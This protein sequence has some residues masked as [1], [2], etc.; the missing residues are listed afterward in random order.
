[1]PSANDERDGDAVRRAGWTREPRRGA[2]RTHATDLVR[3]GAHLRGVQAARPIIRNLQ[4][5]RRL[6]ARSFAI[7]ERPD[8]QSSVR[9]I[10][11]VRHELTLGTQSID[12]NGER[13]DGAAHEELDRLAG[14]D[15]APRCV[16]LERWTHV[17]LE[18]PVQE[19]FTSSCVAVVEQ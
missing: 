12:P 14:P 6:P 2:R 4:R 9:R 7:I 3:T 19:E 8:G 1:M 5:R 15:A 17:S 10:K 11:E 13:S 16:T 18:R